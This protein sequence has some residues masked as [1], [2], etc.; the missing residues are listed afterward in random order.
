[1]SETAL[2]TSIQPLRSLLEEYGQD[3]EP[4]F[5]KA[6]IDPGQVKNPNARLPVHAC[7][8]AWL[9]ASSRIPDPCFGHPS[10]FGALGYAWLASGILREAFERL[11]R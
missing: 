11:A 5:R 1:M 7:N 10:M 8:V 3:P 9:R 2:A 6:G 4:L